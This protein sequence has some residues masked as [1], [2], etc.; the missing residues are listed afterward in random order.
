MASRKVDLC[1]AWSVEAVA[2]K[3]AEHVRL[4]WPDVCTSPATR[5]GADGEVYNQFKIV[6][7]SSSLWQLIHI[8][9]LAA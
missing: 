9:H 7:T 1:S 6:D 5:L 8:A 3:Y 4:S 2:V